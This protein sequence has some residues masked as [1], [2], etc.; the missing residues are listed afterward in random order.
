MRGFVPSRTKQ[1]LT[2]LLRTGDVDGKIPALKV[3]AVEHADSSLSLFIGVHLN[4]AKALAL[5]GDTID[6]NFNGN[7]RTG[8]SESFCERG[9]G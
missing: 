2:T 8:L 6:D 7:N 3:R 9:F 5:I 1:Q 4:K